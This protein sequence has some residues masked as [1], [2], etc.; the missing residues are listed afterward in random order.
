MLTRIFISEDPMKLQR[1]LKNWLDAEQPTVWNYKLDAA[2]DK[3]VMIVTYMILP[4]EPL[5]RA[6]P[7]GISVSAL[8]AS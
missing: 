2:D 1:R 4:G 5:Y 6:W 3:F 8:T 7:G